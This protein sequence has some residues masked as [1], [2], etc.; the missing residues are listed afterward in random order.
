[1]NSSAEVSNGAIQDKAVLIRE[2]N[3]LRLELEQLQPLLTSHQ[4]VVASNGDLRRQVNTLEVEL[5]NE[6]RSK[7]RAQ[8]ADENHVIS[9]LRSK[10]QQCETK[11]QT[12]KKAKES[13]KREL[14]ES[15]NESEEQKERF[16]NLKSKLKETQGALKAAQVDL[17]QSQR[18]PSNPG[19][20]PANIVAGHQQKPPKPKQARVLME[21]PVSAVETSMDDVDI[22]TPG[23]ENVSEVRRQRRRGAE[24]ALP[25]EKSNFSITP[26]LNKSRDATDHPDFGSDKSASGVDLK[27]SP[28]QPR[29][30]RRITSRA[31]S[32]VT[33]RRPA[34]SRQKPSTSLK[35]GA[36]EAETILSRTLLDESD[37]SAKSGMKKRSR[38][39]KVTGATRANN[40]KEDS[41]S[42]AA[43]QKPELKV[44]ASAMEGGAPKD[45]DAEGRK[46]K[47][48]LL[49][50]RGKSI[51]DDEMDVNDNPS[52]P[53][54][55]VPT[56]R[57]RSQLGS[58]ANA[59]AGPGSTFSP[60]KKE[61]RGVNASFI[62]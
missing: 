18:E 50:G 57:G 17:Q 1:M 2:L 52:N 28:E 8:Q 45:R 60:L 49:S 56:K 34:A 51:F 26:F 59:F 54:R 6:R 43:S 44:N 3:S 31:T 20:T 13:L 23:D 55:F 62:G 58:V 38:L 53:L 11:L 46:K 25:G 41:D 22:Q 9:D 61:R 24:H 47:R 33:A 48:K 15:R 4:A 39:G 42:D 21:P 37:T 32:P 16:N 10:L 27:S 40:S 7:L 14:T 5:E 19:E 30:R 36:A 12:Q 29:G 35:K